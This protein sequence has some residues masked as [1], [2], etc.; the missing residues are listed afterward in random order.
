M[1]EGYEHDGKNRNKE[2]VKWGCDALTGNPNIRHS[3]W[4]KSGN[5][6][7]EQILHLGQ[8]QLYSK[9]AIIGGNGEHV[10]YLQ[11]LHKGRL[12]LTRFNADGNEKILFY[13]AR[14][15]L[16]GEVPF[17]SGQPMDS[18]FVAVEPCEVYTFS[19]QCIKDEI[20]KNYPE[21]I[22]NLLE[23]MANKT[24]IISG[25]ACDLASMLNRVGK[26]L[27]YAAEREYTNVVANK[28]VCSKGISQQE[29]AS[30]LGVHRIT[31]NHAVGQLK[32]QGIIGEM[33]KS[34][35]VIL[36]YERLLAL[37]TR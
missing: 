11:Y 31:L 6:M 32:K 16:F 29:L 5:T 21:L 7:W 8:R 25:H 36:D 35:L 27:V 19:Q 13:I 14:G 12:K 3:V 30:I 23:G 10:T 28:V 9:N 15:N 20:M 33:T 24:H 37:A 34:S 1:Q 18:A 2:L 22:V 17:W 4:I 26:V